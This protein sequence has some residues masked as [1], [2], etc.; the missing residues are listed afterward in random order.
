MDWLTGDIPEAIE[1]GPT[2]LETKR[3]AGAAE[4]TEETTS[5]MA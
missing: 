5:N 2:V 3:N 4:Q 1:R